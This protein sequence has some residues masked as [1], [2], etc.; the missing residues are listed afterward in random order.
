MNPLLL[1]FLA[2]AVGA[3]VKDIVQ[4]NKLTMPKIVNG[5]L[6]L[7]FLGALFIGGIAGYLVDGDPVTAALAGYTG[8][9]A[10]ES[11]IAKK[12]STTEITK[13]VTEEI[14]RK[15]AQE[16]SVDPDLAVR[17]AKCESNLDFK[18]VHINKDGSKDRGLFQINNKYHPDV[19][20]EAAFNPITATQFFC[21]SFKAGNLSWWDTT[22]KCWEK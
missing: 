1:L 15:V 22:R 13:S 3:L 11:F 16:E 7:G 19:S 9:S 10:I 17:V 6:V 4:D 8:M 20:D 21:K 12:N 2:G 5:E 14:I 18:A